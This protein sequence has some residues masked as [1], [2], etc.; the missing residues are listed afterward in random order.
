MPKDGESWD[1][2]D[3]PIVVAEL[4]S[5]DC[6]RGVVVWRTDHHFRASADKETMNQIAARQFTALVRWRCRGAPE[7]EFETHQSGF[8]SAEAAALAANGLGHG[9]FDELLV[10]PGTVTLLRDGIAHDGCRLCVFGWVSIGAEFPG[11]PREWAFERTDHI[12]EY[13][14]AIGERFAPYAFRVVD[15]LTREDVAVEFLVTPQG[16]SLVVSRTE[17]RRPQSTPAAV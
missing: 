14:A 8:E 1:V 7:L 15:E 2:G 9:G 11:V 3:G 10:E 4:D 5:A 16:V 13:N 6:E 17:V 12:A